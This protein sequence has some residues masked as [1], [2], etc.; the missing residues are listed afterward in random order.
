MQLLSTLRDQLEREQSPFRVKLLKEDILRLEKLQA[1]VET[2]SDVSEFQKAG[3][4]IGWTQNDMMT[5]R[6]AEPLNRFLDAFYG[7]YL[8]QKTEEEERRVYEAWLYLCTDRN[9]KLIKCL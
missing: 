9:E 8:G 4:R 2:A 5:H 7:Y 3:A 1:L 6:I